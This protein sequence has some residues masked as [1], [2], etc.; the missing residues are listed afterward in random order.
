VTDL[1]DMAEDVKL[2]YLRGKKDG[3]IQGF[4]AGTMSYHDA[5]GEWLIDSEGEEDVWTKRDTHPL[6]D[7][8]C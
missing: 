1:A 4:R 5:L 6:G 2:I 7:E 8:Q 3:W